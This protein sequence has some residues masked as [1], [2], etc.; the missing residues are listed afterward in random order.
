MKNTDYLRQEVAKR[1]AKDSVFTALFKEPEYLL[2]LYQSLHPEDRQT[3]A[4]DLKTVTLTN[5]LTDKAYNDLGFMCGN[6]LMILVE[7][8]STW[9]VNMGVRAG[10]Y[11]FQSYQEYLHDTEQNVYT[12]KKVELPKPELYV[13]FTGKRKK[14]A[15]YISLAEEFFDGDGRFLE[16]RV[17][18]LYAGS[19]EDDILSQ[20]CR[21]TEILDEKVAEYG[22]TREAVLETIR[23]CR[24]NGIL[25]VF[26]A[27]QEKEVI[28]I[29]LAMYDEDMIL[30]IY[31]RSKMAEG[32]R[33]G[34]KYGR[35]AAYSELGFSSKEIAQK[36]NLSEQEVER[37]LK[38]SKL[39][40]DPCSA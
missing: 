13:L 36:M 40:V 27:K 18:V 16:V 1:R 35:I 12:S 21:F 26:L 2:Q 20:Y 19:S 24:E 32:R 14:K 6:R 15:N 8:Q 4:A 29:M 23:I 7:A 37:I 11:L 22:R 31:G 3:T 30:E 33:K 38:S 9:T 17:K 28:D 10:I 5:I 34:E 25:T 39:Q